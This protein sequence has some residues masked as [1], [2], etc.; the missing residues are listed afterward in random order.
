MRSAIFVLGSAIDNTPFDV[1]VDGFMATFGACDIL[2]QFSK[3]S[4]PSLLKVGEL[5]LANAVQTLFGGTQSE[6][7]QVT[8][9]VNG[10][11][12]LSSDFDPASV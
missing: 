11:M 3:A 12:G 4:G 1:G 9:E 7:C 2:I 5:D 8:L 6:H 10:L